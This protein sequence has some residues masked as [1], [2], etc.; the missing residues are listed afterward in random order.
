MNGYYAILEDSK[1]VVEY[2]EQLIARAKVVLIARKENGSNKNPS[3]RG[4]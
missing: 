1:G 4:G 3:W 2:K